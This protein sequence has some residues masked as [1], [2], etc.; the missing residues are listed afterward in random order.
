MAKSEQLVLMMEK[1]GQPVSS[2]RLIAQFEKIL[3]TSQIMKTGNTQR[4]F[5]KLNPDHLGMLKVELIQ[6][7]TGI[8]AK[9]TTAT[10][11]AKDIL[12]SQLQSLKNAFGSQNIQLDKIEITLQTNEQERFLSK[13]SQQENKEKE[14][15]ENKEQK[16]Q[17][18]EF[19]TAFAEALIS[20]EA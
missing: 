17:P 4:M 1:S 18:E 3:A 11:A 7:D 6:K 15:P 20:T 10:G 13:D 16:Q 14:Q 12:E 9:I 19:A 8:I 2:E 5:I